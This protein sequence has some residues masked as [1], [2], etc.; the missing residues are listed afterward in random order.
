MNSK[1]E[2]SGYPTQRAS[3]ACS[4]KRENPGDMKGIDETPDI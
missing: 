1:E 3:V 4:W 2:L